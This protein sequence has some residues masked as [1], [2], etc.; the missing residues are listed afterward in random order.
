MEAKEGW[1]RYG[2][3]RREKQRGTSG[4]GLENKRNGE[5]RCGDG[6]V[7][8]LRS[9]WKNLDGGGISVRTS[10]IILLFIQIQYPAN[11]QED[12]CHQYLISENLAA[13]HNGD[14]IIEFVQP[15]QSTK[16]K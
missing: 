14:M 4:L 11:T 5:G 10:S 1:R 9:S 3:K 2:K 12:I 16:Q 6:G 15:T 13:V 8:L 7:K